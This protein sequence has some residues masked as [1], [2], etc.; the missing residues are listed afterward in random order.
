MKTRIWRVTH[1]NDEHGAL[2]SYYM[3]YSA[4]VLALVESGFALRRD[5]DP[6]NNQTGMA[7]ASGL[8]GDEI[9]HIGWIDAE[10][11]CPACESRELDDTAAPDLLAA[12]RSAAEAAEWA[13]H[14]AE[15]I[16][17]TSEHCGAGTCHRCAAWRKA[18][19][20][21]EIAR[22]AIAKAERGE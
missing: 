13:E 6:D 21:A 5:A 22:A 7:Y 1:G 4:A 19:E 8:L 16:P 11:R 18:G 15:K 10:G 3:T 2:T 12:L 9:A 20:A 17:H 14:A